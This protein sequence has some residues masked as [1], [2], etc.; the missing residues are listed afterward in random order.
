MAFSSST[1]PTTVSLGLAFI[2]ISDKLTRQNYQSW[3]AQVTAAINGAQADHLIHPTATPPSPTITK[4]NAEGKDETT[5]NPDYAVWKAQDQQVLSYLLSGLSKDILGQV[6]TETTAAGA[7]A[8]IEALHAAQSRARVIATRMALANAS[9]GTSMITEYFGKMKALADEMAA[10]GKKLD[11]DDLISYILTGLDEP[12]D[13]VVSAISL[14][15]E[16]LTVHE[17]FTQLVNH[18]QRIDLRG[19]GRHSSANLASRGGHGGGNQYQARGRGGRPCGGFNRGGS[20]GRGGGRNHGPCTVCGRTHGPNFE[21]GVICQVCKKE[22][23]DVDRCFKRFDPNYTAPS[24]PPSRSAS[25]A[26]TSYGIDTNWYFDTGATD[27]ITGEL[28][29]LT[30]R[31]RYTG[32]DRV[33]TTNGSGMEIGHIGHSTL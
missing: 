30:V 27:H 14:R 10:A 20:P 9:K 26:T 23:H 24:P 1:L 21:H 29:K 22:G 28:D 31:D 13:P 4:K 19:G 33:H 15:V 32:G 6:N 7:S 8:A 25:S 18:E 16:P 5:S 12:F 2:P 17:L 3:K 11:D